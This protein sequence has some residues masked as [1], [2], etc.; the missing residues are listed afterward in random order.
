[1]VV[2]FDR[3]FGAFSRVETWNSALHGR[4]S[5]VMWWPYSWWFTLRANRSDVTAS[6]LAMYLQTNDAIIGLF[7]VVFCAHITAVWMCEWHYQCWCFLEITK[8]GTMLSLTYF[9]RDG[10]VHIF[11]CLCVHAYI[12]YIHH[13]HVSCCRATNWYI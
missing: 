11:K 5:D 12:A 3:F 8:M 2:V 10:R 1:M 7:E 6:C 13:V 9:V 4:W